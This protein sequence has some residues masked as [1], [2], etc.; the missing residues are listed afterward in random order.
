MTINGAGSGVKS[1]SRQDILYKELPLVKISSSI[2]CLTVAHTLVVIV[3]MHCDIFLK[4]KSGSKPTHPIS[5]TSLQI[6]IFPH[7]KE[8]YIPTKNQVP[9]NY[10]KLQEEILSRNPKYSKNFRREQPFSL[11]S[12]TQSNRNKKHMWCVYNFPTVH[13]K[14][15]FIGIDADRV[16]ALKFPLLWQLKEKYKARSPYEKYLLSLGFFQSSV[17]QVNPVRPSISQSTAIP[18]IPMPLN[19][20]PRSTI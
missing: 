13:T 1:W 17:S 11:L 15:S 14:V 10:I 3:S 5:Q 20:Q 8:A 9:I 12:L 4:Q 18:T 7:I 2:C 19:W 6:K 16:I